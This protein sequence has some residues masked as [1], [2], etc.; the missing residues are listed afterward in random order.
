MEG[1]E[2]NWWEV[3]TTTMVGGALLENG[4]PETP[5]SFVAAGVG[6]CKVFHVSFQNGALN[7]SEISQGSRSGSNITDAQDPGG[8]LGPHNVR[9]ISRFL[10]VSALLLCTRKAIQIS[11]I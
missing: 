7:V 10:P 4:D 11:A 9:Y 5:W 2:K 3:G 8:R 1:N 6:D